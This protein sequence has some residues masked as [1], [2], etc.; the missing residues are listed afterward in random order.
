ME[1]FENYFDVPA[2]EFTEEDLQELFELFDPEKAESNELLHTSALPEAAKSE[3][4]TLLESLNVL[5]LY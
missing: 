3:N 2:V 4:T 1:F 5:S